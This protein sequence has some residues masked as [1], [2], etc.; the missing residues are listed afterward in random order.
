MIKIKRWL[1]LRYIL[2]AHTKPTLSFL[3]TWNIKKVSLFR[4]LCTHNC[5]TALKNNNYSGY[6]KQ[7]MN[8]EISIRKKW[9][10]EH[11]H[12][13]AHSLFFW[14]LYNSFEGIKKKKTARSLIKYKCLLCFALLAFPSCFMHIHHGNYSTHTHK[15]PQL[16]MPH[17]SSATH[18]WNFLHNYCWN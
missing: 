1:V 14:T 13:L 2:P 12:I 5:K 4:E 9:N 3:N 10:I 7:H 11:L 17:Y 16:I 8:P 18:A 15:I 6:R